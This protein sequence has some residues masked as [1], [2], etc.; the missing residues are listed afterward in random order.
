[1]ENK[2]LIGGAWLVANYD[3]ELVIPLQTLCHIGGRRA[4]QAIENIKTEIYV[5]SHILILRYND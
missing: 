1:M 3:I 4:T 5:V 2:N